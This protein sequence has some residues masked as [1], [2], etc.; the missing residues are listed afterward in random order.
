MKIKQSFC[1]PC[2]QE[3][4]LSVKDLFKEAK[5]IGLDAVEIWFW[6][7]TLD[8]IAEE[9]KSAGL[10]LCSMVGH[11]SHSEGLNNR[12]HHDRIEAEL[13]ASLRKAKQHGIP[14][15]ITLSGNRN[16]GQTDYEGAIVAA[17]GLKRVLPLAEEYGVNL[18]LEL[19]NSKVDHANYQADHTDWAVTVCELCGSERAK[20]LYDIYHMQIM[21]GDIIRTLKRIRPYVGHIHTAGNPGRHQ[22]DDR[23]ELNYRGIANALKDMDYRHFVGHEFFA[24]GQA[25]LDALR[26]AFE[27]MA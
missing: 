18:N 14:G 1:M 22:F 5:A 26:Q 21:E 24:E 3:G 4:G 2:F 17:E 10:V 25:R 6:D 9:A 7:D 15:L 11:G 20:I 27:T 19:L 23:Q 8:T 12:Q 13:V 16:A